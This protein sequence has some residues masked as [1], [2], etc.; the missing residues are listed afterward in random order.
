LRFGLRC[1]IVNNISV[2]RCAAFF[3]Q[4]DVCYDVPGRGRATCDLL[5]SPLAVLSCQGECET[6]S[7]GQGAGALAEPTAGAG[8]ALE[9]CAWGA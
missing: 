1:Y 3:R 8:G 6:A 4:E 9:R 5:G 7:L 2:L